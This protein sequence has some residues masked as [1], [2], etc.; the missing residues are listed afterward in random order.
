[1]RFKKMKETES[2]SL[3]PTFRCTACK[4]SVHS[5]VGPAIVDFHYYLK[6]CPQIH[7]RQ[8]LRSKLDRTKSYTR[9]WLWLKMDR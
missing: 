7:L 9:T 5:A 1:M 8:S 3:D 2:Q 6:L 4:T